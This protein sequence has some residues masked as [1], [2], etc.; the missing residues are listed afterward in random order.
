MVTKSYCIL[1]IREVV[2]NN[3]IKTEFGESSAGFKLHFQLAL[4]RIDLFNCC[5]E[6]VRD[7]Y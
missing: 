5:S 1:V 3:A 6:L 2:E 7:D 4:Q